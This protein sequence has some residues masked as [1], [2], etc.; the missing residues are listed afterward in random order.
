MKRIFF[1]KYKFLI[2]LVGFALLAD[3]F[4]EPRHIFWR[5]LG[6]S[7]KIGVATYFK[8]HSLKLMPES[9]CQDILLEAKEFKTSHV[10]KKQTKEGCGWSSAYSIKNSSSINFSKPSITAR[11]PM[12]LAMHIWLKDIDDL[13][14][15]QL[16]SNIKKIIQSGTYSCRR[17]NFSKNGPWSE[18]AFANAWDISGFELE[19]G[20]VISLL[21]DWKGDK[22]KQKFLRSARNSACRLFSVVL[23]PDYNEVHKDH[24]H[25]DMGSGDTCS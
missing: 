15:Y 20:R 1:K 13:A 14:S 9:F 6:P 19:D 3:I 22:S 21:N 24:F 4:L 8:L 7:S 25:L 5:K 17:I 23:S 12:A 18:H 10:A 11:C 2:I 16:G